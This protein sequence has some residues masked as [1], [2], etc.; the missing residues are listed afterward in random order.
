MRRSICIGILLILFM[1]I[2]LVPWT[3]SAEEEKHM[4]RITLE[5]EALRVEID[6]S[7]GAALTSLYSKQSDKEHLLRKTALFGAWVTSD[8]SI[9]G[10]KR[11]YETDSTAMTI[12]TA[13]QKADKA[14]II[15]EHQDVRYHV[16]L[17]LPEDAACLS[18]QLTVQ[19]DRS[20]AVLARLVLPDIEVL[21]APG[22]AENRM[23]M[24]P[25]EIGGMGSFGGSAI[26]GHGPVANTGMPIA[27]NAMEVAAVFDKESGKGIAFYPVG[28]KA[29]GEQALIQ[30]QINGSSVLGYWAEEIPAGGSVA[31]PVLVISLLNNGWQE[32][33]DQFAAANNVDRDAARDIPKWLLESGAVYST[34]REGTGG[35]Y[36]CLS[37]T[38]DL[39][40]RISSFL[41]LPKLL[42][43]AKS[44]GTTVLELIDFYERADLSGA[45]IPEG[46]EAPAASYY[47]NKGD[48]IPRSDLGGEEAFRE[49]IRLV[50][51]Q[52]GRVLVYVEPYIV[53]EFS[54]LG[55][56]HRE[57]AC[58]TTNGYLD[59]T[60]IMN[61]TMQPATKAWQDEMVNICCK[62]VRDYDVD[63]IQLDSVGWQWNRLYYTEAERKIYSMQE[64]NRG[65]LEIIERVRD[66]MRE[67]K[68]DAVVMSESGSGP[69]IGVNDGG[70]T[71][72]YC[73]NNK[74]GTGYVINAP[75][76]YA[77]PQ[78]NFFSS[79][80]TVN[81]LN[82][83]FAAGY[84]L[85]LC[86]YWLEHA[87]Y[88]RQLVMLRQEYA[89]ALIYGT[90]YFPKADK[91]AV[92]AYRYAGDE[93]ELLIV[94]NA[95]NPMSKQKISLGEELAGS[96][97]KYLLGGEGSLTAG[98][99]GLVELRLANQSLAVFIRQ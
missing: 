31:A 19:N 60:Y 9:G 57:W 42:D 55:R 62:L 17:T 98:D 97:W 66:A 84:G 82:Q 48:Y 18:I 23:A 12:V 77:Y 29:G 95:D 74:T 47:W 13:E 33:I 3:S 87:D 6:L 73:W 50:H 70:F 20:E 89:D 32:A 91:K 99:D 11:L 79:G 71:A 22:K 1:Q 45:K 56:A 26:Y 92:G 90:P 8:L 93:H 96:T 75:T 51:E 35:S 52:G 86:D 41:E 14:E 37:G 10:Y 65:L 94:V 28:G 40:T 15:L 67:I 4:D 7:E 81:S 69:V 61:Y 83:V 80:N 85:S 24:I 68:P 58:Y 76:K 21:T 59:N 30:M 72:D 16:A 5:N 49:G 25:N 78:A 38:T 44:M 39:N 27:F 34:R 88:I 63:G 53:F 54:Q 64:Y 46:W 43:E 2:T 36:Q